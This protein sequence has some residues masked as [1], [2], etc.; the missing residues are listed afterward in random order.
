M[1]FLLVLAILRLV[2][3]DGIPNYSAG[4]SAVTRTLSVDWGGALVAIS[5]AI[6]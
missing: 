2:E 4:E 6:S 5:R 3:V 1:A